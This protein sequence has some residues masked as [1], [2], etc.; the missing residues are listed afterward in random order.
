MK[1]LSLDRYFQIT[2]IRSVTILCRDAS[3]L[4][5][6]IV[7]PKVFST[8]A[9][10]ISKSPRT[11]DESLLRKSDKVSGLEEIGTFQSSDGSE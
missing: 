2:Q 8:I 1:V 4:H 3:M 9:A 5:H 11:I 6:E 7:N 10:I